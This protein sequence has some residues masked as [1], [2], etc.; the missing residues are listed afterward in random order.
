MQVRAPRQVTENVI[1]IFSLMIAA[2]MASM[3]LPVTK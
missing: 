1:I 2:V 3:K